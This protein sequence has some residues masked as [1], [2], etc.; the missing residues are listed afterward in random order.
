MKNFSALAIIL[1]LAAFTLAS[2]WFCAWDLKSTRHDYQAYSTTKKNMLE[3]I[4]NGTDK[5]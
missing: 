5:R 4:D 2:I 1:T 3:G